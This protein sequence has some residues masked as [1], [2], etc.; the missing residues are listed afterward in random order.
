MYPLPTVVRIDGCPGW[1]PGG[2]LSAL[3]PFA[4]PTLAQAGFLDRHDLRAPQ[5]IFPAQL[6]AP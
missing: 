4:N 1:G 5:A 2:R 3:L 6:Q